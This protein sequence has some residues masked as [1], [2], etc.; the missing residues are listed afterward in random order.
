MS[1]SVPSWVYFILYS[2]CFLDLSKWFFTMLG[3]FLAIISSNIFSVPFSLSP[4]GTPII[5]ILVHLM[6]SQSSLI[7]CSF[8]FN[9]FSLFCFISVIFSGLSSALLI[10][11]SASCILLLVASNEFFISVVVFCVSA[12]LSFKSCIS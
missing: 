9:P 5:R 1:Q 12:C 7:L 6:L 4:S 3:T 11:S 10:P 2:S 8:L